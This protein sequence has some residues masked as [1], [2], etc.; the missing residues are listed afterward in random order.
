[1]VCEVVDD[2]PGE[3]FTSMSTGEDELRHV[4]VYKEG[5]VPAE[6]LAEQEEALARAQAMTQD[7]AAA[8][9]PRSKRKDM[10][11]M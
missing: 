2:F 7:A 9:A 1:M 3:P 4:V 11:G 6:I 5:G 8:H 10:Y